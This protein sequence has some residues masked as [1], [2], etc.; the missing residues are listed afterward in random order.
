MGYKLY[1]SSL[2]AGFVIQAA[3]EEAGADYDLVEVNFE[4]REHRSAAYRS[5]NPTGQI[6][7]MVLP[8]G[9]VLTESVAMVLHLAETFP[10]AE[11]LPAPGSVERARAY[12]WLLFMA[13]NPY[14]GYQ[15][16]YYSKRFTTEIDGA[17]GIRKSAIAHINAGFDLLES[18][19]DK[20]SYLAGSTRSIADTYL[21]M[22][23]TWSPRANDVLLHRRNLT[24]VVMEVCARPVVREIWNRYYPDG[25][26]FDSTASRVHKKDS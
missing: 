18:V 16:Y 14:A 3:L 12:R 5:M 10:E 6:P 7:T 1:W 21:T 25:P 8:D 11:L 17:E 9:T 2:T 26:R 13:T 15:R 23:V 4:N 22:M 19:L 24:R 20:Q